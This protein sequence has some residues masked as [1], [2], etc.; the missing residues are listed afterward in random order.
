MN[1][2]LD[3]AIRRIDNRLDHHESRFDKQDE[4]IGAVE[5]FQSWLIGI[6]TG[7]GA[8]FGFLIEL[9]RKKLDL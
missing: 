3:D 2:D 4:R 6:G 9:V 8:V 7:A 5:R 1:G